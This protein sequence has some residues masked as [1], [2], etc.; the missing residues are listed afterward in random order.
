M[1]RIGIIAAVAVAGLGIIVGLAFLYA[2]FGTSCRVT[3]TSSVPGVA[4]TPGPEICQ[5]YSLVQAQPVWPMP[6]LAII[7]WSLAPSAT[8]I[9]LIRR[10][11]GQASAKAWII[12][13]TIAEGTVLISFGAAPIFVPLVLL[14]LIIVTALGLTASPS[15]PSTCR[16]DRSATPPGQ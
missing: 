11:R 15:R 1:K 6:L 16:F 4:T 13:G 14:P 9:G 12:A 5:S 10:L 3:A 7:V 2:P 8:A